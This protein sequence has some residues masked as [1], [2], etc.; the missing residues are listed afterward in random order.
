MPTMTRAPKLRRINFR[1]S[2]AQ[3]DLLRRG[4]N[5]KGQSVTEFIVESACTVAECELAEERDFKLPPQQWKAFL[6][7]LDKPALANPALR[8]LLSRSSVIEQ[9]NRKRA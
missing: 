2:D 1:I 6:E 7:A 8:R 4:A 5:A 3:E 9:A